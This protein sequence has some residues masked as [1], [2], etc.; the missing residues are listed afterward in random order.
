MHVF[1]KKKAG[2]VYIKD[3]SFG[4]IYLSRDQGV[5]VYSVNLEDGHFREHFVG[6]ASLKLDTRRDLYL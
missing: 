6:S 4:D 5:L 1:F 2:F 3:K